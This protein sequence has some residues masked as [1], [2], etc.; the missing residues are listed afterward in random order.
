MCLSTVFRDSGDRHEEV[1]RDIAQIK[2]ERDGFLLINLFGE[3][4]F[5]RGK[6]KHVDFVDEHSV[7][8]EE[9]RKET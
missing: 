6:I 1:M 4:I 9:D 2:A 8:I 7:V 3:Q 5:V